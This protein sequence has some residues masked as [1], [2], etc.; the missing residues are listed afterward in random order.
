V[1]KLSGGPYLSSLT[2]SDSRLGSLFQRLID[3]VNRVATAASV[4]PVGETA[5]PSSP[6]GIQVSAP[7]VGSGSEMLHLSIVDN[8]PLN[9]GIRYFS[10]IATSPSFGN[11]VVASVDHGASRTT[12]PLPLPT[13]DGTGAKHTFYVQSYSQYPGSK[14]SKPVVYGGAASPIGI[15]MAGTSKLTLLPSQGSGTAPQQGTKSGQGLG[16]QPSRGAVGPKRRT[17]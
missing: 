5:P 16:A 2:Q 1:A 6:N 9:R 14:P 12:H 17:A 3:G 13:F 4:E 10:D 11:S 15:Q 7:A 8:Q